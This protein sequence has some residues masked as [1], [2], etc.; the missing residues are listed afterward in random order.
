MPA[1]LK[2]GY[3]EDVAMLH[4]EVYKGFQLETIIKDLPEGI[5]GPGE[6]PSVQKPEEPS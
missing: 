2:L 3:S 5:T 4:G 1:G 6:L